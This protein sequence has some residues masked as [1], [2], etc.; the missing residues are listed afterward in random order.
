MNAFFYLEHISFSS[1]TKQKPK[2]K[3]SV[4]WKK[5]VNHKTF[6]IHLMCI[7]S[8]CQFM[9]WLKSENV[10]YS[11]IYDNSSSYKKLIKNLLASYP[12]QG[13]NL[14]F[15]SFCELTPWKYKGIA[16]VYW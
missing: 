9:W 1:K 16:R 6:K 8:N 13:L 10:K 5:L 4:F 7:L 3:F 11:D 14:M 15:A 12:H 2:Y